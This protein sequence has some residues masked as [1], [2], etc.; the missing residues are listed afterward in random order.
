M[1]ERETLNLS[2][3]IVIYAT[4]FLHIIF[5]PDT[6][7]NT[8][9]ISTKAASS[10]ASSYSP[11]YGYIGGHSSRGWRPSSFS[12][13]QYLEFR[14]SAATYVTS[15]E[16]K[17][18]TGSNYYVK[19]FNVRYYNSTAGAWVSVITVEKLKIGTLK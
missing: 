7:A 16:I 8:I 12:G 17:G 5:L 1:R 19:T 4:A 9:S 18:A 3:V 2:L 13:T 10:T 6:T 14:F 15:M 11:N